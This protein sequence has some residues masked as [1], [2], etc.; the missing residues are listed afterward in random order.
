VTHIDTKISFTVLIATFILTGCTQFQTGM[1]N[2]GSNSAGSGSGITS[3]GDGT[4]TLRRDAIATSASQLFS[5]LSNSIPGF[6]ASFGQAS[7]QTISACSSGGQVVTYNNCGNVNGTT[8]IS[9]SA[10]SCSILSSN[11]IDIAPNLTFGSSMSL[12]SASGTDYRGQTMGGGYGIS[13]SIINLS[14]SFAEPGTHIVNTSSNPF[15]YYSR[16]TSA[17]NVSVNVSDMTLNVN[18]GALELIDNSNQYV[19]SLVADNLTFG[20]SCLCPVAGSLNGTLAGNFSGSI[21]VTFN[22]CGSMTVTAL[23]SSDT[24]SVSSCHP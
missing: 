15:D 2:P 12:S 7:C 6:S 24:V 8:S 11:I 18:G 14:A 23:G 3:Q 20:T 19:A 4:P 5:D 16:T 17:F 9:Y 13:Y 21:S 10:A 22:S 1:A